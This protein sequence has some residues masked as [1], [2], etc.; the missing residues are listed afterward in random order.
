M[1]SLLPRNSQHVRWLPCED[2]PVVLEEGGERAFLCRVEAGPDH[3]GLVRLIVLEDDGLVRHGWRELRLGGRLLGGDL[4]LIRREVLCYL[5]NKGRVPGSFQGVGEL[6]VLSLAC[7]RCLQIS[8]DQEDPLGSRHL[9][10]KIRMV[11]DCYELG[12]SW[13]PKYG[14]VGGL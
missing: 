12:E 13:S 11:G 2:V 6:D 3:C 8:I 14:V 10:E 1:L 9:Q 7:V 5:S 4:L